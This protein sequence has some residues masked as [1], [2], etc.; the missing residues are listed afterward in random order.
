M[1]R[2]GKTRPEL[3]CECGWEGNAEEG[4]G[5]PLDSHESLIT[6]QVVDRVHGPIVGIHL[7][8][9]ESAGDQFLL[10]SIRKEWA[11]I[12]AHRLM[13]RAMNL[14]KLASQIG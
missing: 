2:V 13:W 4:I 11:S 12:I 7:G 10:Y 1:A 5:S 14:G 6:F 3:L 9:A 8:Y